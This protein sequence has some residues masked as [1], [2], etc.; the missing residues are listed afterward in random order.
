M[1]TEIER[2]FLIDSALLQRSGQLKLAKKTRFQ[3]AY[4]SRGSDQED[5]N[6]NTVRVRIAGT[7]AF[8]TIKGPTHGISRAEFEYEIPLADAQEL[9]MLCK[10]PSVQKTRYYLQYETCIWE[11]DEFHG[12]NAGLWLAEI[13]LPSE[14]ATFMTPPWLGKE[15]SDDP[16]YHN[17]ALALQPMPVPPISD[18][19]G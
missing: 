3:Q 9:M 7:Q 10:G 12:N 5:G 4:L 18:K 17:S 15:V 6:G 2:K 11:V 16:R 8:L 1:A 19:T 13:E 14:S